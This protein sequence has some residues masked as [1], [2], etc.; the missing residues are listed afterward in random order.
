MKKNKYQKIENY[1][2]KYHLNKAKRMA[3][4]RNEIRKNE[5]KK[6]YVVLRLKDKV[7]F[8]TSHPQNYQDK[9][10]YKVQS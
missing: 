5:I 10:I 1:N 8:T 3:K 7:T 2:T 9:S 4:E 6:M